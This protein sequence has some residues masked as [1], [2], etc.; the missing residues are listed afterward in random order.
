MTFHSRM[1]QDGYINVIP[2]PGVDS[3]GNTI[4]YGSRFSVFIEETFKESHETNMD[5]WAAIDPYRP[6]Y[7]MLRSLRRSVEL[8]LQLESAVDDFLGEM[9][10]P[11]H[12]YRYP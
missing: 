2:H 5:G 7:E 12:I 11:I 8:M 10:F 6:D 3:K 4:P 9:L 1:N